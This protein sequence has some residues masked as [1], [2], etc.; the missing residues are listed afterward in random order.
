MKH[1]HSQPAKHKSKHP[2]IRHVAHHKLVH[3]IVNKLVQPIQPVMH[4]PEAIVE[5]KPEKEESKIADK[6]EISIDG[7]KVTIE[8]RKEKLGYVYY[9][10][11]PSVNIATA[12]LMK[13]IRDELITVT[14]I[15]MKELAD[16]ES[17]FVIKQRFIRDAVKIIREKLPHLN[18]ETEKFLIGKL[19]QDM[20][21]L[22]EIE[23]LINDPILEEIV[24]P[25]SKEPIRVY[26]K[27]F[28]WLETN[29]TI[30]REEDIINYANIIARRVG[31]QITVLSPLLDAHLVTGD[32]VNAVLYPV[33]TKGNTITIRKFAR[34]PYTIID[35]INNK[36]CDSETAALL[37]LAM[38]YEMNIL[39]SGG[40]GSGKTSFL[41][42]CLPFIPPNQRI[43]SIEDTRELMLPEFLYWTPLVTR[44]PNPEGKGEV[45]MLDLLINSLRMR[46]D[47]IILGE[48]RKQQEAMVL[49]EAMHTGHS[50][51][52]TVHADSASET[53]A[54][55]V[56]PPISVPPNLLRSVHLNVVMFRDR[57]KGIRRIL[58]I[59]EFEAEKNTARSN[60][61]Y[62]WVPEEDKM[63]LHSESSRFFESIFRNT[64]MS[65]TEINKV[66]A[67]KKQILEWLIK[68]NIRSLE[69][70][71]RVMNLYY[72]SK[73]TLLKAMKE[74]SIAWIR[75]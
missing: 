53:I 26:N 41:N 61:L 52:A 39:I 55:L 54:R 2:A 7:A 16:P 23:F 57:R 42:A 70:F 5:R 67:D 35:M 66:L 24:I 63:V 58:Q 11:V 50:V 68:N 19:I 13:E 12:T 65:E 22:G 21:G 69:E 34:D 62:R 30:R 51:Y 56:N 20:L 14:T 10:N 48:M 71:G 75:G 59:A 25:S 17:F 6:Y 33:N 40:T 4:K 27:K 31:R 44:T 3:T 18:E 29:L 36:T 47:R 73:D 43:I 46:P 72:K 45:S 28:G 38:E 49:F 1:H 60:I 15:S 32:R 9:L 8:V 74:N 37:W 64:G